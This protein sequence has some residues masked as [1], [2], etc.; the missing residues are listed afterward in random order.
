MTLTPQ[1]LSLY[2][3]VQLL[4]PYTQQ[5]RTRLSV[6]GPSYHSPLQPWH[7][8]REHAQGTAV[9]ALRVMESATRSQEHELGS[10]LPEQASHAGYH[11]LLRV[12][13]GDCR[14]LAR[15]YDQY[16]WLGKAHGE[17]D[18][19]EE[20]TRENGGGTRYTSQLGREMPKPRSIS[21]RR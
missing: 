3:P 7:S 15:S 13:E 4:F 16:S 10:V 19:Q 20:S 18:G 5:H 11:M 2:S 6:P 14:S 12:Q 8:C 21:S 1:Q 17:V 9:N